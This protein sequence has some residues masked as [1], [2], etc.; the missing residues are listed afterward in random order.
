MAFCR[1]CHAPLGDPA[2][3]PDALAQAEGVS[4]VQCHSAS[5]A[6]LASPRR[7][8]ATAPE[9]QGALG[10]QRLCASCHQFDFVVDRG[11]GRAL[12]HSRTPMQ[13]TVGEW[14]RAARYWRS[15]GT[16]ARS[17]VQC[18]MP[19]GTHE[20]R[21]V[22]QQA[23]LRRAVT[24]RVRACRRRERWRVY[25]TIS[26]S[27]DVGHAVPTGDLHRQLRIV[28][29]SESGA[30]ASRVLTRHFE[31]QLI[32]DR[33]VAAEILGRSGQVHR[34]S[35]M[36]SSS[37]EDREWMS[38]GE[39]FFARVERYDGRVAPPGPE[40]TD[41]FVLD[42]PAP[43]D[44]RPTWRLEHWRTAPEIAQRQ[45]LSTHE[46]ITIME[47]GIAQPCDDRQPSSSL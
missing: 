26:P 5:R 6:H 15:Q 27:E 4:C 34:P 20:V 43:S 46:I 23:F 36:M 1:G 12:W 8:P 33:G 16:S 18:H 39:A 44:R 38:E 37:E 31:R 40:A 14:E 17:C 7:V 10:A 41:T 19:G 24:V 25:A 47:E 11:E 30:E 32:V 13:D 42:V 2:N 3:E 45:G 35:L 9:H 29:A 28:I 22:E 21:G